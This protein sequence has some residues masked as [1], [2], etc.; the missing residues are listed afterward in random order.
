[1]GD[2]LCLVIYFYWITSLEVM[3]IHPSEGGSIG[4]TGAD[5]GL[6][7]ETAFLRT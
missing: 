1:M 7:G 4:N 5:L 6:A 2:I 3:D